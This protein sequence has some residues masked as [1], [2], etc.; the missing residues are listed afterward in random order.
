MI[1][2]DENVTQ[3][4]SDQRQKFVLLF[5]FLLLYAKL[6]LLHEPLKV[7]LIYCVSMQ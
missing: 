7:E 5:L 4:S 6:C 3:N 1:H 2:A